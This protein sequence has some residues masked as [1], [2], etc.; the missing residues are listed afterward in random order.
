MHKLRSDA[1]EW[2][3]AALALGLLLSFGIAFWVVASYFSQLFPPGIYRYAAFF[4]AFTGICIVL[5]SAYSPE[6]SSSLLLLILP[7]SARLSSFFVITLGDILIPIDAILIW[8]VWLLILF[9]KKMAKDSIYRYWQIFLITVIISFLAHPSGQ[10]LSIII[11]GILTQFI[12]YQ[13][14]EITCNSLADIKRLIAILTC[15]IQFCCLFA[16]IQPFL[17]RGGLDYFNIRFS[18]VFY[19]PVIFASVIILLWPFC[20]ALELPRAFSRR[21]GI[22]LK[23][24]MISI[25]LIVL[26]LAGSRGGVLVFIIQILLIVFNIRRMN[27][28]AAK[29]AYAVAAVAIIFIGIVFWTNGDIIINTVAGLRR[30]SSVDFNEA[31]SSADERVLGFRGGLELGTSYPLFGV[32]LGNFRYMYPITNAAS[33]GMLALESAHNFI[34]NL[35]A[36]VGIIATI[37]WIAMLVLIF[38]RLRKIK[39]YL[40]STEEYILYISL[41]VSFI[42]FTL[43]GF[44]FYGEFVHNNVGL[45]MLLYFVVMAM[46]SVLYNKLKAWRRNA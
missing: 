36:E 12:M 2:S 22:A 34:V 38:G 23:F 33:G 42:G 7:I 35:F 10:A 18:S 24:V 19:N 6:L 37:I 29:T 45:P 1:F 27:K 8:A 11:V 28:R 30:F 17:N 4:I 46:A 39:K 31:G 43:Y 25:C 20:F 41:L 15:V 26:L 44:V 3:L 32:G 21:I 13:I 16:F 40:Q 5:I 9:S 14:I